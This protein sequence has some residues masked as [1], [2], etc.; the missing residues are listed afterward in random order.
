MRRGIAWLPALVALPL[1]A[2]A[3]APIADPEHGAI[4]K[5]VYSNRYFGLAYPLPPGWDEGLAPPPPSLLGYYV[6]STPQPEAAIGATLLVAAQ[7]EFFAARPMADAMAMAEDLRESA[8]RTKGLEAGPAPQRVTI[9]G[10]SFA[11]VEIGGAVLSRVVLAT[12]IRCHI[13]SFTFASPDRAVL[14][15]LVESAQALSFP[16]EDGEPPPVC[17]KDYASADTILH[18]VEPVLSG[19]P[20]M[21]I[22]TRIIIG[23]DGKVKH[24]HVIRAFPGQAQAIETALAQWTFKP[25]LAGGQPAEVETGLVFEYKPGGK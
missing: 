25:Y 14:E 17:L 9:A 19:T 21:R 6:L 1:A 8:A 2:A 20:F 18:K 7:D 23:R 3:A 22:P 13:V 10:H 16:A 24:V 15:K 4:A 5:G 12:D 11:R